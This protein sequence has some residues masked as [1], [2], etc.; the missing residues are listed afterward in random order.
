MFR[1]GQI[2][3]V[4]VEISPEN[5]GFGRAKVVSTDNNRIFLHIKSS[6]GKKLV[7]PQGTKI[8]F[9][10]NIFENR[11]NGLWSSVVVDTKMLKGLPA[12]EC[13]RPKFESARQQRRQPRVAVRFPVAFLQ[14]ND[15]ELSAITRNLS[16]SGIG[17]SIDGDRAAR[18]EPGSQI[19]FVIKTALCDIALRAKVIRTTYDWL[20]NCTIIGLEFVSMEETSI[21]ALDRILLWLGTKP[22]NNTESQ[23]DLEQRT[24]SRWLKSNPDSHN[25]IRARSR[26]GTD[27]PSKDQV[28]TLDA[29]K[30]N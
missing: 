25:F 24:L 29:K 10:D 16:R 2:F 22:R 13:K 17:I 15:R 4:K 14:G 20:S 21:K 7:L 12:F 30:E 23:K 18:F 26:S 11:F 8:W 5:S 19:E 27:E 9:V 1:E 6:K 28:E 3:K